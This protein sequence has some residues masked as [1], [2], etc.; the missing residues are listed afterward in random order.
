MSWSDLEGR[1]NPSF[2]RVFGEDPA[3]YSPRG[4]EPHSLTVVFGRPDHIEGIEPAY[5]HAWVN[6]ADFSVDPAPGDLLTMA[7]GN[8][9]TVFSVHR[10]GAGVWLSLNLNAR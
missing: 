2:T 1:V 5:R 7:D 10:E 9:Y 6:L 4:A 3:T 8:A